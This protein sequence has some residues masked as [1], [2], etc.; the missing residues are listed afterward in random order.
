MKN[1]TN[2]VTLG[3]LS[4][5][6]TNFL[7]IIELCCQRKGCILFSS[8]CFP[9]FSSSAASTNFKASTVS[10]SFKQLKRFSINQSTV[11]PVLNEKSSFNL[12]SDNANVGWG[13]Q[14]ELNI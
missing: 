9:S 5:E 12:H 1:F 8:V 10:S 13:F 7:E 14:E 3:T 2:S 11:Y 6:L 4:N